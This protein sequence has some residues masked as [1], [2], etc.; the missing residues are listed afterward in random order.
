MGKVQY[1]KCGLDE[2]GR[3]PLAG[4]VTAAA[5]VLTDRTPLDL[6]ADSKAMTPARRLRAR[7]AL[8]DTTIWALGWANHEEI[9]ALNILNASLLAMERAFTH[10][11]ALLCSKP[12]LAL[13]DGNRAPDLPTTV[14]TVVH[15]D[16]TVP[17][18]QA[19]SIIAKTARDAWMDRYAL[20][21]PR[22]GFE[23]HKGY[24]TVEHKRL[25][26]EFGPCPIHRLSFRGVAR[27]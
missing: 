25:I 16:A 4:P 19:A 23:R 14:E 3:G 9:D 24:P 20:T 13:V 8:V 27:G 2:V 10:L 7:V 11:A 1:G 17:E 21:E 26:A 15:G 18:I 12:L 5:V 6:L 22:Y